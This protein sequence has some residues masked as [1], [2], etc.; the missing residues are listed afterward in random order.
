MG[1]G[2]PGC[3]GSSGI[4]LW[5]VAAGWLALV[6]MAAQ[7]FELRFEG[8]GTPLSNGEMQALRAELGRVIRAHAAAFRRPLPADFRIV[9]RISRTRREYEDQAEAAGRS[10]RGQ[11]GFTTVVQRWQTEPVRRLLSAESLIETWRDQ[12]PTALMAVLLHESTHAVT[13]G[14]AGAMPLWF[15]EG[16]AELLGT[17]AAGAFRLKRQEEARRWAAMAWRLEEGRMPALQAFLEAGSY[18][19]WDRLFGGDRSAAYTASYTLFFHL[20]NQ[21]GA[22]AFVTTWLDSARP[23]DQ[24]AAGTAFVEHVSRRWPGGVPALERD[25]HALIRAKAATLSGEVAAGV[26][27]AGSR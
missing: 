26:K 20:C 25:W 9:Y 10:V 14:Y 3:W 27:G 1:E 15:K 22:L 2:Q 7:G 16:S 13:G 21:P 4:C 19:A 8:S 17:P 12:T 23:N 24:T 11:I 5:R 6:L 18:E